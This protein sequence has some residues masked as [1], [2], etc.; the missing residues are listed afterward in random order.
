MLSVH[1]EFAFILNDIRN[2]REAAIAEM[3]NASTETLQQI[4]GAIL[5]Y[6][7]LLKAY[8]ADKVIARHSDML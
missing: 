8:S 6:D 5:A 7:A 2:Q 4:S 3:A 1:R